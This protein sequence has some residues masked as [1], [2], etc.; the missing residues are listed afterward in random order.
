MKTLLLLASLTLS[1][2]SCSKKSMVL[3]CTETYQYEGRPQLNFNRTIEYP[4]RDDNDLAEY[5]MLTGVLIWVKRP[6]E[7]SGTHYA[8]KYL[9]N[10]RFTSKC[11]MK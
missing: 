8:V 2:F 6:V 3:T 4:Y 11:E 10:V 7:F 5:N 1:L 9:T